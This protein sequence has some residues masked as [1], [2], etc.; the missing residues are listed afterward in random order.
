LTY[1]KTD[2][3]EN[4]AEELTEETPLLEWGILNSIEIL[5]IIKLCESNFGVQISDTA[6]TSTNFATVTSIADL[7]VRSPKREAS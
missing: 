3:L 4:R 7:V 1:I 6:V 2:V 5:R